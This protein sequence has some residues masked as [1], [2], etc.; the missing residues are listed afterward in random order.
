MG[1]I[2]DVSDVI[3]LARSL[4]LSLSLSLSSSFPRFVPHTGEI[5]N[6]SRISAV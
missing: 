6:V 3:R 5:V 1:E 2:G 4:S